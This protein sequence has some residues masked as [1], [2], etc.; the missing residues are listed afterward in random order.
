MVEY[1]VNLKVH[2]PLKLAD[3][4]GYAVLR[5]KLRQ[6][7]VFR[8]LNNRIELVPQVRRLGDYAVDE[9]PLQRVHHQHEADQVLDVLRKKN[10]LSPSS[11]GLRK[12][13]AYFAKRP[14]LGK[15][16]CPRYHS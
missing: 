14:A 4:R 7:I 9:R 6:V 3:F 15:L 13:D 16:H 1:K 8:A 11:R 2:D 10:R 12:I 5:L